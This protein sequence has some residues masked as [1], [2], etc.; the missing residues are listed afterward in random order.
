MIPAVYC[1]TDDSVESATEVLL[2]FQNTTYTV[3]GSAVDR[4]TLIGAGSQTIWDPNWIV[5]G[6]GL[7]QGEG[8]FL[9]L[10]LQW[11]LAGCSIKFVLK[12]DEPL[13]ASGT[14]FNLWKFE[15]P[16]FNEAWFI[17][18]DHQGSQQ[19]FD[20]IGDFHIFNVPATH[21]P[22]LPHSSVITLAASFT[23][24]KI[25]MSINGNAV[26]SIAGLTAV[27]EPVGVYFAYSRTVRSILIRSP[28]VE[29]SELPSL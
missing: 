4:D 19:P 29:D 2:D 21:L 7:Q 13:A 28:A 16:D 8:A 12:A 26:D 27:P 6:S 18:L 1:G 9:G 14:S 3:D 10:A 25:A 17:D 15:D 5:P 11:F 22:T 20:G 23:S 24:D